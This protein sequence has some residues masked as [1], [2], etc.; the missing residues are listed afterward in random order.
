MGDKR[1]HCNENVKYLAKLTV[2]PVCHSNFHKGCVYKYQIQNDA[3]DCCSKL[4]TSVTTSRSPLKRIL[5]QQSKILLKKKK[6]RLPAI[7]SAN[8]F[9][10][11]TTTIQYAMDT[12]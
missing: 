11:I 1:K 6:V 9:I 10:N 5:M 3:N 7:F 2:C 4:S 8:I 12:H